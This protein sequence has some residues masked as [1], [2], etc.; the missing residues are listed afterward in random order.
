MSKEYLRFVRKSPLFQEKQIRDNYR[1]FSDKQL[2][3]ELD[4][5]RSFCLSNSVVDRGNKINN[6]SILIEGY[7]SFR[8]NIELLK[9]CALYIEEIVI[10]DPMFEQTAP[11]SEMSRATSKLLGMRERDGLKRAQIAESAKYIMQLKTAIAGNFVKFTPLSYLHESPEEIPI[12]FSENLFSDVL[13]KELLSFFHENA[14]ISPLFK[15]ENGWGVGNPKDLKPCRGIDIHFDDNI[16]MSFFLMQ[17]QV[18]AIDEETGMVSFIQELPDEPPSDEMFNNWVFQSINRS[19]EGIYHRIFEELSIAQQYKSTYLTT[20]PFVAE[21]LSKNISTGKQDL[22]VDVANYVLDMNLPILDGVSLEK[23]M[24]IR[25]KDGEAF[26]NFRLELEQQLRNLRQITN[27][28]ELQMKIANVSHELAE[29]QINKIDRKIS[30]IKRRMVSD[31]FIFVGGLVALIQ[32]EGLGIPAL[33][34]AISKGY[35]TYSDYISEVKENPSFF[36]WK[37]KNKK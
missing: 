27:S 24:D 30:D 13:P 36:L 6:L 22:K 1:K 12:Y 29:T 28:D 5:Y 16:S 35:Q 32:A 23:I 21:L 18:T 33:T 19:A 37:L 9:Q 2:L 34:Y 17:Q 8:P 25:V 15:L 26:K 31:A 7:N 4:L 11:E 3:E 20:S 10:N 14:K